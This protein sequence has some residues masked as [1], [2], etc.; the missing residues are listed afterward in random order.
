MATPLSLPATTH[1]LSELSEI[2]LRPANL[3]SISREVLKPS[4]ELILIKASLE[5]V[6][7]IE[8]SLEIAKA[9]TGDACFLSLE[10]DSFVSRFQDLIEPSSP[11]ET[12]APSLDRI[13]VTEPTCAP[14]T[15]PALPSATFQVRRVPSVPPETSC[16]PLLTKAKEVTGP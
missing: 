14:T 12:A 13:E 4:P 11:E 8:P 1:F 2:L 15:R 6:A 3:V 16:K 7:I 10:E 9:I 5:A